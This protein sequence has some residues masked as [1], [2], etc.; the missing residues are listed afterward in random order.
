MPRPL[1]GALL[2]ITGASAGIGAAL[3]RL[4]HAAGCRLVLAAR[5]G[6][7]LAALNRELGGGHLTVPCDVAK[8][9]D[10]VQL[11]AAAA[12]LGRIDC[13]VCNAGY[14]L[15]QSIGSTTAEDW[16][17]IW[18]TNVLGSVDCI[19]AALP[20]LLAQ[21]PVAGWR[22]Q[23]MLVSS[24]LAR[25]ARPLGGAY[26]ATKAAQL[27]IAEALRLELRDQRIAV[28]SVHPVGTDSEFMAAAARV[29]VGTPWPVT[30]REPRQRPE[31]VAAC[32][33]RAIARPR[34]EVW[35]LWWARYVVGLGCMFPRLADGIM[36]RTIA[37]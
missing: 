24:I 15:A 17:A 31:H 9:A 12:N 23:I 20:L 33:L 28:T 37:Q 4:A 5:R 1:S 6:E 13:V 22:G 32:M 3:A 21:D 34:P 25:R 11:I 16:D 8:P 30:A 26:S 35:P 18:R 36:A 19:R 7:R 14:G 29:G 10:C 27:S 2:V